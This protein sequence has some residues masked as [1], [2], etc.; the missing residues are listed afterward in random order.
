MSVPRQPNM[1]RA[2]IFPQQ[3]GGCGRGNASLHRVP[4]C[5]LQITDPTW[6]SCLFRLITD[7]LPAK[8]EQSYLRYVSISEDESYSLSFS[9]RGRQ[10]LRWEGGC[11]GWKAG[12][13]RV[14]RPEPVRT[15]IGSSN[16][17][18]SRGVLFPETLNPLC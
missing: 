11:R 18:L 14:C 17:S 2:R 9:E 5:F 10:T 6:D 16:T 7:D 4:E 3:R 13:T 1:A 12:P 8:L 15:G